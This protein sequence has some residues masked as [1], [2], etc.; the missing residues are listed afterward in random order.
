VVEPP[1]TVSDAGAARQAVTRSAIVRSGESRVTT[2]ASGSSTSRA[3]G[4]TS[5]RVAEAGTV[6]WA[7]TSPSPISMSMVP[8]PRSYTRRRRPT[9]PPAPG[10]WK[11]STL[12]ATPLTSRAVPT[13]RA[14]TS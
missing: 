12:L 10:R 2:N 9:A 14:V 8:L 6:C 1:P 11:I 3:T 7:P 5:A 13:A 4:V